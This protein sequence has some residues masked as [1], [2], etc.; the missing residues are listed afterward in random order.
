MQRKTAK[1]WIR[2]YEETGDVEKKRTGFAPVMFTQ[3]SARHRNIIARH[4]EDPFL[5]TKIT[6]SEHGIAVK[7]VRK[8]LHAAGFRTY[9]PAKK[10]E[11]SYA[12]R[13]ARVRF[14]QQYLDFDWCNNIVIYTDEKSFK[15]DKDGRKILWRQLGRRYDECCV[16]PTRTS[17]RIT[18]AYWGWMSSMG[19]GELIE[20]SGRM[21]KE[22]YLEVLR[23][24]MLPTVRVAYPDGQ[25]YLIQ[26]NCSVHKAG[27]VTQ[28]L[29]SQK[30][31]TTITWPA[32]SPDLNLIENLWGQMVLNWDPSNIRSSQ[33]L[34][35]LVETTWESLRGGV[36][37]ASMVEGMRGRLQKVIDNDGR[38][39]K[40]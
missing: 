38:A 15:S 2:R 29:N 26:D 17:G 28:W 30:D 12:H 14:A 33:N 19:P 3:Q 7:T 9:R 4:T 32:K 34:R 37:C 13:Q 25:I 23:D 40:Y 27:I 22:T 10:I 20:I 35:N 39:L 5:S 21:K 6:A 18:L 1:L 24:V 8:H 11:L 36:L 31:I 16:L